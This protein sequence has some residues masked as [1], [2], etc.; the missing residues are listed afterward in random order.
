M[1][2][3]LK[4]KKN[5]SDE[6]LSNNLP[7]PTVA[8]GE[9]LTD[10]SLETADLPALTDEYK[11]E[12][13]K[14][15]TELAVLGK[16]KGVKD[17]SESADVIAF[18]RLLGESTD[19]IK[20]DFHLHEI[21]RFCARL[22]KLTVRYELKESEAIKIVDNCSKLAVSEI[23]VSPAY[24]GIYKNAVNKSGIEGQNVCA[25][26]DFPFGESTYKSKITDIKSCLKYGVDGFTVVMPAV[27]VNDTGAFKSQMKKLCRATKKPTGVAFSASELDVEKIKLILK[28]AEKKGISSLTFAFGDETEEAIRGKCEIMRKNKGKVEIRILG[29]VVSAEAVAQIVKLGADKVIT[30]YADEIAKELA[31]RFKIKKVKLS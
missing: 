5:N 16:T 31:K 24:L 10:E 6:E 27:S 23:L 15:E 19:A 29:N 14:S 7:V 11:N 12:I 22:S 4:K 9:N 13:Q 30:P 18:S 2:E 3:F 21:R 1:F 8:D 26:I 17:V 28:T 25:L 20:D